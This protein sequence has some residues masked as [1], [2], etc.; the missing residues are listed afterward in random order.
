[1][2]GFSAKYTDEGVKVKTGQYPGTYWCG[3]C[4]SVIANTYGFAS[5]GV[6]CA[7]CGMHNRCDFRPPLPSETIGGL[8]E[9]G[10]MT[11][12]VYEVLV[13]VLWRIE[14]LEQSAEMLDSLLF[15]HF[16]EEDHA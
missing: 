3:N 15:P 14:S 4:G 12:A 16:S 5:A 9:H 13:N 8:L 1:M 11:R 10:S 7:T 6:D 2:S